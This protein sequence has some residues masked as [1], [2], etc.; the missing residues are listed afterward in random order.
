VI[1]DHERKAA[2]L[3][4]TIESIVNIFSVMGSD[5]VSAV[6]DEKRKAQSKLLK[7]LLPGVRKGKRSS[8]M[9]P[10]RNGTFVSD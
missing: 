5:A 2:R 9:D 4:Y 8:L 6:S 7:M 3:Y 10:R 1:D